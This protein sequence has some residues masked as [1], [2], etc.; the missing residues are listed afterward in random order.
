MGQKIKTLSIVFGLLFTGVSCAR[1]EPVAPQPEPVSQ[2]TENVHV[3]SPQFS[4]PLTSPITIT[5][6]ARGTWFFEGSFS[7]VLT[8]SNNEVLGTAIAQAQGEWMTTE[9]VPFT[10]TLN[11]A[12]PKNILH[13][14]ATLNFKKDN[15]SGL[16]EH[17]DAV[18]FPVE[19]IVK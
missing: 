16:P 18:Q 17:D 12:L 5:G 14:K 10:A 11:F 3:D 7:I 9:F 15:P 6:S 1:P 19:L 4:S 2:V 8:G 13:T